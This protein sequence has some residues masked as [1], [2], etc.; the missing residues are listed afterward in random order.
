MKDDIHLVSQHANNDIHSLEVPGRYKAISYHPTAPSF[1]FP[2]LFSPQSGSPSL[3]H[4]HP[5]HYS[6]EP[7]G[8]ESQQWHSP[9]PRPSPARPGP[10]QISPPLPTKP[11]KP[12]ILR[13]PLHLVESPTRAPS[14]IQHLK[15][16]DHCVVPSLRAPPDPAGRGR[17][18]RCRRTR[19]I[20]VVRPKGRSR[21][22]LHLRHRVSPPVRRSLVPVVVVVV[23]VVAAAAGGGH[24]VHCRQIRCIGRG[25][26]CVRR[27]RLVWWGDWRLEWGQGW[28]IG[29]RSLGRG[30]RGWRG[31]HCRCRRGG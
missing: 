23:V 5:S 19:C 13:P 4:E 18:S 22:R 24:R 6:Q 25:R 1:S 3:S 8:T 7:L 11:P 14:T 10:D 20:A 12:D 21:L 9:N 26:G 30:F 27:V 28:C 16:L 17:P 15:S 2:A 29:C 31:C